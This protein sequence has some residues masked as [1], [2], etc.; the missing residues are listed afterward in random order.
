MVNNG[1]GHPAAYA[2]NIQHRT[3]LRFQLRPGRARETHGSEE[4][5]RE[6]IGP[7]FIGQFQKIS[8]LGSA[9]IVDDDVDLPVSL[10][11]KIHGSLRRVHL[12]QVHCER[13]RASAFALDLLHRVFQQIRVARAQHYL[14]SLSRQTQGDG[15]SDAAVRPSHNRDLALQ[16]GF[17]GFSIMLV[18]EIAV[19]AQPTRPSSQ[20]RRAKFMPVVR[21]AAGNALEMYDFQIFGYYAAAIAVTFFPTGHEFASLMLALA[22][23]G[24]GFPDATAGRHY[25]GRLHRSSRPTRRPAAH[26]RADGFRNFG[27]GLP[28]RLRGTG[29]GRAAAGPGRPSA[30]RILGGGGTWRRL[31]LSLGDRAAQSQGLLRELAIGQPASGCDVRRAARHRVDVDAIE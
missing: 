30:A 22:T 7:V 18:P 31:G 9:G 6:P 25:P 26:A 15:T 5:Q 11:R 17:H 3:R 20:S 27:C 21:V 14:R 2:R 19:L 12:A 24:A 23:F 10:E 1:S 8:A 16:S 13:R 28:A 29:A 4:F